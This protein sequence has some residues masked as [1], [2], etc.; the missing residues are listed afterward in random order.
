MIEMWPGQGT[1]LSNSTHLN[2]LP[3]SV[4]LIFELTAWF[5]CATCRLIM[6]NICDK[7]LGNP[8]MQAGQD[9]DRWPHAHTYTEAPLWVSGLD[10][11]YEKGRNSIKNSNYSFSLC[12]FSN[13]H[14]ILPF[15]TNK[16]SA[17][18]DFDIV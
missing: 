11:N 17:A 8:M 16:K 5:L 12:I 13:P 9:S 6:E 3:L 18:D 10:K 14:P 15:P 4:T 1:V 7:F 2:L